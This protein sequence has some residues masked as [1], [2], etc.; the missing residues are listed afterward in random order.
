[1]KALSTSRTLFTA[2]VAVAVL[3]SA[4]AIGQAQAH[5]RM[6]GDGERGGMMH[7]GMSHHR[8]GGGEMGGPMMGLFGGRGLERM[9]DSVNATDDQRRQI[10]EIADAARKDIGDQ[11]QAHKGLRDEMMA[12]FTQPTVDARAVESVRER[13]AAQHEA[14][15]KR[16][17]QAMLDMSRVLTPEQR[18]GLAE[19]MKQREARRLEHREGHRGMRQAPDGAAPGAGRP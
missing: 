15:S 18:Q 19:R 13:M 8:H 5:G 17:L 9:L 10:G 14:T 12:L 6:M 2:A 3:G 1:M 7:A 16:R 11:R 4:V